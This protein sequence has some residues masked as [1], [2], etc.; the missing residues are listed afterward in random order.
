M[1]FSEIIGLFKEGK[2][3]SK[4]HV[5]NLLEIAMSD[6]ELDEEEYSFLMKLAKKHGVSKRELHKIEKNPTTVVFELPEDSNEKF[7]QF[8]ELV[9]M[10]TI[11]GKVMDEEMRLCRIFARK[12]GYNNPDELVEKVTLNIGNG[13]SWEE[14]HKRV[15]P[16]L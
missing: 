2:S 8:Y 11:D 12:F 1:K 10:M 4:S 14:T 13:Q 5:K 9:N 6:S 3:T 7:E 16:I 15:A